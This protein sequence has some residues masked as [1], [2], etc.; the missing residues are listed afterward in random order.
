MKANAIIIVIGPSGSGKSSFVKKAIDDMDVL[1]DIITYTTRP[2]RSGESEAN[3]Y[4][5]ISKEEF[6]YKIEQGFFV[7]WAQVHGNLYGSSNEQFIAAWQRKKAIIMD[8]DV[9]GA[10]TIK[11]KYPQAFTVFIKPPNLETLR[12]RLA[13]RDGNSSD[14]DLRMQNAEKEMQMADQFDA[15]LINDQFTTSYQHFK[16]LIEDF[17]NTK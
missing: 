4:H 13:L 3:P 9:Q 5:F 14:L 10:K 17:L 15:Q 2:M 1:E 7:E 16:K 8:V 11:A 12:E 6:K